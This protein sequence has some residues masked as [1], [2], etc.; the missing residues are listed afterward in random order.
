MSRPIDH[1]QRKR[2][3]LRTALDLFAEYGYAGVTFQ[4]LA[5]ASGVSRTTIYKYFAN[6]REILDHAIGYLV[7]TT[8]ESVR[9]LVADTATGAVAKIEGIS[10]LVVDVLYRERSLLTAVM[11]YLLGRKREGENITAKIRRHTGRARAL[12]RHLFREG[13][14][15]REFREASPDA[16]A[17]LLYALL[18]SAIMEAVLTGSMDREDL[19]GT[20]RLAVRSLQA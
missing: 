7:E 4:L 3:I 6:K 19:R 9:A 8:S 15:R 5:D 10:E 18:E 17:G 20:L 16:C 13:I 2:F 12:F 14:R 1:E 11:E